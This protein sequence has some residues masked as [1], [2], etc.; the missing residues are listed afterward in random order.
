MLHFHHPQAS[1][2]SERRLAHRHGRRAL[3]ASL[4]LGVLLGLFF[5][6]WLPFFI[7]NMAQVRSAKARGH[8]V[9]CVVFLLRPLPPLFLWLVWLH[10][11]DSLPVLFFIHAS[12][13]RVLKLR[14][15]TRHHLETGLFVLTSSSRPAFLRDSSQSFGCTNTI[16]TLINYKSIPFLTNVNSYYAS[17][18]VH[19]DQLNIKHIKLG[20][21][22]SRMHVFSFNEELNLL[23]MTLTLVCRLSTS[24]SFDFPS[25]PSRFSP[26]HRD[27]TVCVL[28]FH[29]TLNVVCE[30]PPPS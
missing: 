16:Q 20:D 5:S 23:V 12:V 29:F 17:A 28:S 14:K 24:Q 22:E 8:E 25:V 1:V 4:T 3:K 2:N 11:C 27:L 19:Y 10:V 15:N 6:T 9:I 18:C 26:E 7:T 13:W 21:M 30:T